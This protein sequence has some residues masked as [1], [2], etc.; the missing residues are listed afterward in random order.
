MERIKYF[1][2]LGLMLAASASGCGEAGGMQP[3]QGHDNQPGENV[4]VSTNND[5]MD[6]F[7]RMSK[8]YK[9]LA[10][11]RSVLFQEAQTK[12]WPVVRHLMLH[13]P[14]DPEEHKVDDQF[15]LGRELLVAPFLK[16]HLKNLWV[17][18]GVGRS[19]RV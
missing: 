9:A 12:G 15:L 18:G 3:G 10:F 1:S 8:V 17:C 4:Q 19:P 7:A 5:T 11:Y 13:Y 6:H 14:D 16:P 2:V